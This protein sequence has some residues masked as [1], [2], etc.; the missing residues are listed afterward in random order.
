VILRGK[1]SLQKTLGYLFLL[2][3]IL[4]N[5]AANGAPVSPEAVSEKSSGTLE[6]M[7]VASGNVVLELDLSRFGESAFDKSQSGTDRKS[8]V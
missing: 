6:K 3:L 7:I 5:I 4:G 8:V 1:T 2:L